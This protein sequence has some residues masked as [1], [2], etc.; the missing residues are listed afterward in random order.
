[1]HRLVLVPF[2][3]TVAF[4]PLPFG[5]N[6]E[7]AWDPLAAIVGLLLIATAALALIDREW[8]R[9]AF[10]PM[11]ALLVPAILFGLVVAWGLV[12]LWGG[13]PE[14]WASPL[15]ANATFGLAETRRSIAFDREQ[16]WSALLR[17]LTYAGV[18]VLAAAFGSNAFDGRRLLASVVSVAALMTLYSMAAATVNSQARFTGIA[19]WVPL[20][21]FFSGTFV[22]SNSYATYAGIS[23]MAAMVLAFRPA[24]RQS[25]PEGAAERWRRRLAVL[26]GMRGVWFSLAI[27]LF[28]GVLFSGSRA[29][30]VSL[31]LGLT[32]L[33]AFYSRGVTRAAFV[34]LV[35]LTTLVVIVFTPGGD[36]L[37]EKST[38]LGTA[39]TDR[40]TLYQMTL[41]AIALRPM[42]GWGM[43]SFA[44]LFGVFQ[45]VSMVNHFNQAHSL[46]LELAFDLG[47]PVA[48]A[49]VLAV[50]W[51]AGRCLIGSETRGRDRELAGLGVF[52]TVLVGS[53]SLFDFSLQI[54]AVTCTYVSMLGLAW[55]QSWSTRSLLNG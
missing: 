26:S 39:A 7:W 8:C 17:L 28:M 42:V 14:S 34:A 54:P 52:A 50:A 10:A 43:N 27:I 32:S 4:C 31:L 46:Y 35:L 55:A 30:S 23:A 36:M 1:M 24:S 3:L 47:I 37:F 15:S 22:G 25:G 41:G 19:L 5:S 9:H 16:Q 6:R 13:T 21:E 2:I 53:H 45:P 12:Q 51:I 20:A 18:F 44:E 33:V 29:G 11:R 38:R 49:L 40:A 48:C